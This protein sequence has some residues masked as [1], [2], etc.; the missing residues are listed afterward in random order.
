MVAKLALAKKLEE[1]AR[2]LKVLPTQEKAI[3]SKAVEIKPNQTIYRILDSKFSFIKCADNNVI[4][5]L[6]GSKG[7]NSRVVLGFFNIKEG[8]N[9]YY[10]SEFEV[11]VPRDFHSYFIEPDKDQIFVTSQDPFIFMNKTFNST[12]LTFKVL[13][14]DGK[15]IDY[16]IPKVAGKCPNSSE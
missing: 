4:V 13:T 8:D 9:D 6:L 14:A 7:D 11:I 3:Q 1:E 15:S 5:G 2:R 12:G 16:I 10:E